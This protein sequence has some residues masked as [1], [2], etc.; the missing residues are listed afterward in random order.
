VSSHGA[1]ASRSADLGLSWL[2]VLAL[3]TGGAFIGALSGLAT[4]WDGAY[5]AFKALDAQSPYVPHGRV[6]NVLLQAPV[7]LAA[8]L[9][10][11]LGVLRLIFGLTY[12]A[13]PVVALAASWVVVRHRRPELFV[14][15]VL[16]VCMGTLAGQMNPSSEALQA[17]Q[18]AWPALLAAV[19]GVEPSDAPAWT[20]VVASG[21]YVALAHPFGA[22]LL[23]GVLI[24]AVIRRHRAV[25]ALEA[26]LA[27][28]A[29]AETLVTNDA[30]QAERVAL[31]TV[32]DGLSKSL[33]GEPIVSIILV[34]I[35]GVCILTSGRTR[36][37]DRLG[38]I[39]VCFEVLAIAVLLPWAIDPRAWNGAI[40]F[41]TFAGLAI[42]PTAILAFAD[43]S[44]RP[45]VPNIWRRR[46]A[47]IAAAG[48]ATILSASGLSVQQLE[49]PLAAVAKSGAVTC[50]PQESL[51][52]VP[53]TMLA[54]WATPSLSLLLGGRTATSV[55]LWS[56]LCPQL[57]AD[58]VVML[59]PWDERP[60]GGPGW[61]DLRRLADTR[62]SG[63]DGGGTPTVVA[64][65][66]ATAAVHPGPAVD[67]REPRRTPG[68]PQPP[69]TGAPGDRIV[70]TRF[71]TLA[72]AS[73]HRSPRG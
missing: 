23:V 57:A 5:Y 51:P 58:H 4:N 42:L 34:T 43:A 10:D 38:A 7:I 22:P 65:F 11:R 13:V 48:F 46:A 3:A 41:R 36:R 21:L 16:C 53:G 26:S 24:I 29:I 68:G 32:L 20:S 72:P 18:L 44:L 73:E 47:F 55:A 12:L 1:D 54:S 49:A 28:V 39:G 17:A 64:S 33:A 56:D 40:E 25:A 69:P 14:W 52:G 31:S 67:R 30:Y 50:L 19:A 71:P 61:F 8:G 35:A 66:R 59:A 60:T 15:P 62:T 27:A 70:S 2:A 63:W 9:T 37:P 6:V 45:S